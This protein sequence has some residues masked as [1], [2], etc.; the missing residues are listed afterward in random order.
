MKTRAYQRILASLITMIAAASSVLAGDTTRLDSAIHYQAQLKSN[1]LPVN[2]ICHFRFGL[3]TNP[4]FNVG[5]IQGVDVNG[6]TVVNGQVDLEIDFGFE[7]PHF[8]RRRL[9]D[10][11]AAPRVDYV[12]R[13]RRRGGNAVQECRWS[14]PWR[15]ATLF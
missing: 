5:F 2:D 11:K 10:R 14:T 12:P 4:D 9:L 13:H 7:A 15:I 1:G 6:V 3:W 8:D